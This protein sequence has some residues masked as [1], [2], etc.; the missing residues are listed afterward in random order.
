[1]QSSVNGSLLRNRNASQKN[2]LTASNI[3]NFLEIFIGKISVTIVSGFLEKCE[4]NFLVK[5]EKKGDK[6]IVLT[7]SDKTV[8]TYGRLSDDLIAV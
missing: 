3:L 2:F 7:C 8:K 4:R 6:W 5:P 1:M